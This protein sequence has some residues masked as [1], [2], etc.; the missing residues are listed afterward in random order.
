MAKFGN[1]T[2]QPVSVY[3]HLNELRFMALCRL[4]NI[5]C[6]MNRLTTEGKEHAVIMKQFFVS[7]LVFCTLGLAG[8]WGLLEWHQATNPV[9]IIED[10]YYCYRKQD[11]KCLNNL[12]DS[13]AVVTN[14]LVESEADTLR[15]VESDGKSDP[16]KQLGAK[17]GMG[18]LQTLK[19]VL[20]STL[21]NALGRTV[22]D[23]TI[24][25]N[26]NDIAPWQAKLFT[27]YPHTKELDTQT[28]KLEPGL[29][30]LTIQRQANT[31]PLKFRVQRQQNQWK[32]TSIPI[33]ELRSKG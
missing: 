7:T 24:Q 3:L 25:R 13:D 12:V 21:E 17:L 14:F 6:K 8:I 10:A 4:V 26:V 16:F 33:N 11:G 23:E 15:S 19:P 32:V 30:E 31:T 18:M 2:P 29:F 22:Q 5:S 20:K 27:L 1:V 28:T 9:S